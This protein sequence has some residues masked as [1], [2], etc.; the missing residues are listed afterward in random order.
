[1]TPSANNGIQTRIRLPSLQDKGIENKVKVSVPRG[2]MENRQMLNAMEL[3]SQDKTS[4]G[5]YLQHA[6]G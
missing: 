4:Q 2:S 1:M 3:Q 5:S 6:S